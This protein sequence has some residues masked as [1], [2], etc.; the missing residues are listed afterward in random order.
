MLSSGNPRGHSRV[1][2]QFGHAVTAGLLV[3]LSLRAQ[4]MTVTLIAHCIMTVPA[5]ALLHPHECMARQVMLKEAAC[6]TGK[7]QDKI[8]IPASGKD[9]SSSKMDPCYVASSKLLHL[10][11]VKLR[12]HV[13]NGPIVLGDTPAP[14]DSSTS[15]VIHARP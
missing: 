2:A 1:R 11:G 10:A 9:A 3:G 14:A 12:Q 8:A 4:S 13:L 7:L 15:P 5:G 6:C